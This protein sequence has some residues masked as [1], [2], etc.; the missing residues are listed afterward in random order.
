MKVNEILNEAKELR[1][2]MAKASEIA[3]RLHEK[4]PE[5]EEPAISA[6]CSVIRA[7]LLQT[8]RQEEMLAEMLRAKEAL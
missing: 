7:F 2:L 5:M 4:L 6:Q 1:Q 8:E 3:Q